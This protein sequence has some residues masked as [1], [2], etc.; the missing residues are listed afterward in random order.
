MTV[1]G[2]SRLLDHLEDRRDARGQ[3]VLDVWMSHGDRVDALPPG[4]V[5]TATGTI[6][7]AAMAR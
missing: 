4:F 2:A 1:T 7:F 6:P 3:A 5:A